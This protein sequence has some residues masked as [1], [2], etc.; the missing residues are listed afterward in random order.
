[1]EILLYFILLLAVTPNSTKS[2]TDLCE[3]DFVEPEDRAELLI[4][5]DVMHVVRE[6]EASNK[7]AQES[8]ETLR[9][10]CW[11]SVEYM[12]RL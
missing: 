7:G 10:D 5:C 2:G 12:V 8:E 3:W 4:K 9:N 6:T 11:G 1:M